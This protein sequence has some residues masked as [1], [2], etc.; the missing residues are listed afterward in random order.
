M[1]SNEIENLNTFPLRIFGEGK[2][3]L[4]CPYELVSNDDI[5]IRFYENNQKI[6]HFELIS[7]HDK[8]KRHFLLSKIKEN[9]ILTAGGWLFTGPVEVFSWKSK[10]DPKGIKDHEREEINLL[11]QIKMIHVSGDKENETGGLENAVDEH[12]KRLGGLEVDSL[13][14]L[15]AKETYDAIQNQ[16]PRY[17]YGRD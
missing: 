10:D 16:V 4:A 1:E 6:V 13:T 5:T 9:Y 2:R 8:F 3:Y 11:N 17:S 15:Q 7:R 12:I 14:L